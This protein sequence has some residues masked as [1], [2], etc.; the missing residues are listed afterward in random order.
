MNNKNIVWLQLRTA[1]FRLYGSR[2]SSVGLDPSCRLDDWEIAGL[3]P[4]KDLDISEN[5]EQKE[6]RRIKNAAWERVTTYSL[7]KAY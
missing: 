7:V 1:A 4:E 2:A 3:N 6:I 5:S